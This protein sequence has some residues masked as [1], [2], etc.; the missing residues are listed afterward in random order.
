MQIL[1]TENTEDTLRTPS[2]AVK[3]LYAGDSF[4]LLDGCLN[5]GG[6]EKI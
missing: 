5:R 4:H 6:I 1:T 2:K 3:R